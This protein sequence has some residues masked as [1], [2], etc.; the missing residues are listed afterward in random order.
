LF[1]L[2]VLKKKIVK[3]LCLHNEKDKDKDNVDAWEKVYKELHKLHI[4]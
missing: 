3:F 4:T 2:L 1:T